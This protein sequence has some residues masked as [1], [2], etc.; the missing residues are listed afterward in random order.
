LKT[1][2]HYDRIASFYELPG[3]GGEIFYAKPRRRAV[4]ELRLSS[5]AVVLDIA[6]G[7][8][9]NFP[10]LQRAIGPEGRI[11]GLDYSHGM[12][13]RAT[14]KIEANN[15]TNVTLIHEDARNLS[16]ELLQPYLG[17]RWLDAVICTLGFTVVPEW[18]SVFDQSFALLEAGGRYV[19][20]DDRKFEGAKRVLNPLVCLFFTLAASAD[21]HRQPW[22]RLETGVT[23]F[24]MTHFM[25]GF[26]FVASGSKP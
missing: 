25:R 26:N 7:T 24:R 18:E 2:K 14:R 21:C 11:I 17:E 4:E 19:I 12:L 8:G 1:Q 6:C 20:M 9:L 15:W 10:L 5:G 23:D 22:K 13:Q 16:R 3:I